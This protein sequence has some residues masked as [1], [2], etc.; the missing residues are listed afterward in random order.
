L[1]KRKNVDKLNLEL[2]QGAQRLGKRKDVGE[3]P[4][5]LKIIQD[6]GKKLTVI[7]DDWIVIADLIEEIKRYAKRNRLE[8]VFLW[9]N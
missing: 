9:V 1:G 6:K 4:V 2:I 8:K 5:K 3:Y 7:A